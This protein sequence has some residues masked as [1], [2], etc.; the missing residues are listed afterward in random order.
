MRLYTPI[1]SNGVTTSGTIPLPEDFID[2]ASAGSIAASSEMM[3]DRIAHIGARTTLIYNNIEIDDPGSPYTLATTDGTVD[4]LSQ[5]FTPSPLPSSGN[6]MLEVDGLCAVL[7]NSDTADHI[8]ITL[9]WYDSYSGGPGGFLRDSITEKTPTYFSSTAIYMQARLSWAWIV[10][11][12]GKVA[13]WKVVLGV[14]AYG[15]NHN[16][17]RLKLAVRLSSFIS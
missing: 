4:Y 13:P 5:Q 7:S 12:T 6:V 11:P 9:S 17:R 16:I 10:S 15:H 8:G 14:T 3:A 2:Y 1:P